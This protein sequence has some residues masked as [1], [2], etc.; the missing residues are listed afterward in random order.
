MIYIIRDN[1][2]QYG[3]Y[4][5]GL[6]NPEKTAYSVPSWKRFIRYIYLHSPNV[7]YDVALTSRGISGWRKR[8]RDADGHPMQSLGLLWCAAWDFIHGIKREPHLTWP[9]DTRT[10]LQLLTFCSNSGNTPPLR[11]WSWLADKEIPRNKTR[12][13]QEIWEEFCAECGHNES[14]IVHTGVN[15]CVVPGMPGALCKSGMCIQWTGAGIQ[16]YFRMV[17]DA[18][19]I[20]HSALEEMWWEHVREAFPGERILRHVPLPSS[21]MHIDI[22][23]PERGVGV[24]VQGAQHWLSLRHFGGTEAFAMRQERDAC[25]RMLCSLL[26]VHLMEV[27]PSTQINTGLD[28]LAAL[29]H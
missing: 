22:Y 12:Y 29:L 14:Q 3:R 26:N 7:Q 23:F 5:T 10:R 11:A 2:I 9:E 17:A 18:D 16:G 19:K 4:I 15:V 1:R 6:D 20:Q 21:R 24:E 8:W 25:K 13:W 27:T 28:K